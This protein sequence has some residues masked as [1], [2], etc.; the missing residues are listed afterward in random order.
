MVRMTKIFLSDLH[1]R[2][3]CSVFKLSEQR[4]ER[5]TRLEVD[6]TV[7]DLDDHIVLELAVERYEFKAG[8]HGSVRGLCVVYERPPHHDATERCDCVSEH[9]RAVSMGTAIVLR[10]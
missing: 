1:L 8:L 9:V 3:H 2:H 7:L 10:A 6:R 5:F 4:A